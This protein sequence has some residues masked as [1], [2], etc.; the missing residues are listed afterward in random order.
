MRVGHHLGANRSKK[1]K[2][3]VVSSVFLGGLVAVSNATLMFTLRHSIASWFTADANVIQAAVDLFP[4]ACLAHI[5][6]VCK[7][8]KK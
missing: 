8:K 3:C 2:I 1:I 5:V 6:M 4:V 7:K